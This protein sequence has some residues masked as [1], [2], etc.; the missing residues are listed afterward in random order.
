MEL[1]IWGM[2]YEK[3]LADVIARHQR[4]LGHKVHF[5]TGLDEH[6]QKVQQV[7]L[8]RQINPQQLVDEIA[9]TFRA[10][11]KSLNISNDDYIRTTEARHKSVVQEFFTETL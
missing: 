4:M 1:L 8:K 6:G 11:L 9:E 5:L 2:P 10:M 7:A 3:V